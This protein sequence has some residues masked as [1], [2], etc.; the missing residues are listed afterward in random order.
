VV[1]A[2]AALKATESWGTDLESTGWK[3]WAQAMEADGTAVSKRGEHDVREDLRESVLQY[4]DARTHLAAELLDH[5]EA[6]RHAMPHRF[7][8]IEE[9]FGWSKAPDP[10]FTIRGQEQRWSR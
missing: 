8:L 4:L 2:G 3:R 1:S 6:W 10:G 7:A 9:L 5:L